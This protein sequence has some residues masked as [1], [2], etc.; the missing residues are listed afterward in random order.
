MAALIE[1]LLLEFFKLPER[2]VRGCEQDKG[3]RCALEALREPRII[4]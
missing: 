2:Q 4:Q 3:Y 1:R